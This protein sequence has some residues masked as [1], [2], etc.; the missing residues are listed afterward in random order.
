MA[1]VWGGAIGDVGDRGSRD[2]IPRLGAGT[3]PQG[4]AAA[5]AR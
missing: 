4:A 5:P 3:K 2:E 1:L